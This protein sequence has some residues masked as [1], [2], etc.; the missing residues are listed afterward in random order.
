[1]VEKEGFL[2][3]AYIRLNNYREL[4]IEKNNSA[5]DVAMETAVPDNLNKSNQRP[6]TA[7]SG[8]SRKSG[9]TKSQ[10]SG[11]SM[12]DSQA[13]SEDFVYEKLPKQ[14]T[15]I[16]T[17]HYNHEFSVIVQHTEACYFVR[18]S[19]IEAAKHHWKELANV[20]T[21]NVLNHISVKQ[22][23]LDKKMDDHLFAFA[24]FGL[25]GAYS[26]KNVRILYKT[27]LKEEQIL[28]QDYTTNHLEHK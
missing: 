7:L 8:N 24:D 13:D 11:K 2:E 3:K 22:R 26:D 14:A 16:D 23:T 18:K 12:R 5:I 10:R 20:N 25:G 21:N 19:I 15:F 28:H 9:K 27:F 17:V 1:M 4:T 6:Q